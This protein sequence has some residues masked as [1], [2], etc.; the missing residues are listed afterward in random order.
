MPRKSRRKV[1]Y[2]IDSWKEQAEK[3]KVDLASI[4]R[5]LN[6]NQ[7]IKE[8]IENLKSDLIVLASIENK[9]GIDSGFSVSKLYKEGIERLVKYAEKLNI[10]SKIDS[11][12]GEKPFI[13]P[14]YKSPGFKAIESLRNR[15]N[16]VYKR[17]G[18]KVLT[19]EGSS[20]PGY[21]EPS[22]T[23]KVIFV[24]VDVD[25]IPPDYLLTGADSSK[26]VSG[27]TADSVAI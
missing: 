5:S 3:V 6:H 2:T 14:N 9:V 20:Y 22:D 25:N 4:V 15:A 8:P 27:Q 16:A 17:D 13:G 19:Y 1:E 12:R 21:G 26:G 10:Q 11:F 24:E 7:C 23:F 18:K